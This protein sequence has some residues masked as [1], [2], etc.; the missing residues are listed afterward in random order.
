MGARLEITRTEHTGAQLRGLSNRCSDGA[1]RRILALAM[2]LEGRA[3]TEAAELNGMDRQTSCDWGHRYSAFG[4]AGLKSCRSP[5]R[6]PALTQLQRAELLD[7]V[8]PATAVRRAS[9]HEIIGKGD[10][11]ALKDVRSHLVV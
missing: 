1:V 11:G 9:A 2:I 4:V 3:R 6:A 7:L 5:G 8:I 10:R